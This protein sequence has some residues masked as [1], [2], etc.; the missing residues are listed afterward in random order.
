VRRVLEDYR[1]APIDDRLKAALIAIEK[2]VRSP[3]AFG[4]EDVRAARAAG[5]SDGALADALYVAF[6][7]NIYT[8]LADTLGWQVPDAPVFRQMAKRLLKR[9]YSM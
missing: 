9:G 2:T 3:E 7:F 4:A 1:T 6:L 5:V 8:R